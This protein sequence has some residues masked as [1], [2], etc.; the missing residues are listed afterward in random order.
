MTA[1]YTTADCVQEKLLE[2]MKSR[3]ADMESRLRERFETGDI[4]LNQA[5]SK[6][7]SMLDSMVGEY[8]R[9]DS[10]ETLMI[11]RTESKVPQWSEKL[12]PS[13]QMGGEPT[14]AFR[15]SN[16]RQVKRPEFEENLNH[17]PQVS[18]KHLVNTQGYERCDIEKLK[19]R[20][21]KALPDDDLDP[22]SNFSTKFALKSKPNLQEVRLL[23]DVPREIKSKTHFDTIKI[24]EFSSTGK[25]WNNYKTEP[26]KEMS[27][28]TRNIDLSHTSK[29]EDLFGG[30]NDFASTIDAGRNLIRSISADITNGP[31]HAA[32]LVDLDIK[33]AKLR[34]ENSH[35][36]SSFA[37]KS[38]QVS[39]E[40]SRPILATPGNE[41]P[42]NR[43]QAFM[44]SGV[45]VNL[46]R[47][48]APSESVKI[49]AYL[50]SGKLAKPLPRPLKGSSRE[51]PENS[52][53][54]TPTRD[55]ISMVNHLDHSR[56]K[57]KAMAVTPIQIN[58]V[59]KPF[60]PSISSAMSKMENIFGTF[61]KTKSYWEQAHRRRN[62][63]KG[64]N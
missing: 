17:Q 44:S 37:S 5:E 50:M 39:K 46:E 34:R 33:I 2:S 59:Q 24:E 26:L 36:E 41:I 20:L 29:L 12:T 4:L 32:R 21:R 48:L 1:A 51:E 3:M 56:T 19:E 31:N 60:V 42:K 27:R 7:Q 58:T 57:V 11:K 35:C 28:P 8:S 22:K 53:L 61:T 15:N 64:K 52:V 62:S 43:D 49:P 54:Y 30:T 40:N 55:Q 16:P 18:A 38:K 47:M 23:E 45:K 25:S 9:Q 14:Q 10:K 63:G 13:R 6:N